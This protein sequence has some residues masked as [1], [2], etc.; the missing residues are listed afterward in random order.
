MLLSGRNNDIKLDVIFENTIV[1][2]NLL[3]I[4]DSLKD[5]VNII[6]K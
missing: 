1:S 2:D 3:E 6:I 4:Q 5:Y